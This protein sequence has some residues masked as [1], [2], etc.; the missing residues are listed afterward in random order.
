MGGYPVVFATLD[1]PA[2]ICDPCRDRWGRTC[3]RRSCRRRDE[4]QRTQTG[5]AGARWGTGVA[6][7]RWGRWAN[8]PRVEAA[9]LPAVRRSASKVRCQGGGDAGRAEARR[10]G[11]RRRTQTS[12][13]G[14]PFRTKGTCGRQ[15]WKQRHG[16]YP[17]RPARSG[18][19]PAVGEKRTGLCP[20]HISAPAAGE[21]AAGNTW[22]GFRSGRRRG[23]EP[24]E[25]DGG[26]CERGEDQS[27]SLLTSAPTMGFVGVSGA[28]H[29]GM[30]DAMSVTLTRP[31]GT[32]S[33]RL[34]EG[35]SNSDAGTRGAR[36]A[37]VA[38][39]A[40]AFAPGYHVP[41]PSVRLRDLRSAG[42]RRGAAHGGMGGVCGR[43]GLTRLT[44][45]A[46]ATS[47][48]RTPERREGGRRNDR[49]GGAA[50]EKVSAV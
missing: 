32:L 9:R 34:G 2:T 4:G 50:K 19:G 45:L 46:T 6:P 37:L 39:R 22:E 16:T 41:A 44:G 40:R 8:Q 14:L 31:A 3:G 29:G 43:T 18:C 36:P 12:P 48:H 13:P 25:L 47:R 33:H 20:Y 38:L 15:D 21:T 7:R 24:L 49:H 17:G 35:D 30:V 28:A 10:R 27:E 5:C 23:D 42:L 26:A 11:G 1:R